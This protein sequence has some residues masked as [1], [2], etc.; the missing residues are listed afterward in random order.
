MVIYDDKMFIFFMN[1]PFNV[2][3]NFFNIFRNSCS[4][5]FCRTKTRGSEYFS[6]GHDVDTSLYPLDLDPA[7]ETLVFISF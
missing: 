7:S 3:R 5:R 4:S 1:Y 6:V 2:L